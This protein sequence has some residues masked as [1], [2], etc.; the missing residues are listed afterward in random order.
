M[1]MSKYVLGIDNGGTVIKA[2]LY[3]LSG[4]EVAVASSKAEMSIPKP[5]HTERDANE[6]WEANVQAIASVI[7][8]SGIDAG[9]IVGVSTTGHGNGLYLVDES[10]F[11]VYPGIYSTDARGQGYVDEWYE[12]GTFDRVLPKTMQS[13]WSG[14]P[15]ALLA[16]LRDNSP[17]I[18]EKARWIL[19][20]KDYI[21]Y[22]LTGE[23]Y[24][25]IT[26]MSGSSL[27]N[28]RDVSYDRELLG[29]FGLEA[30]F[31]MLPPLKYS[32]EVCGY[33]SKGA[34]EKTGLRE[35]TPV[36]GGLFD[37][38]ACAI[39]T[40]I[41]DEKKLCIIAGTWSI[42]EYISKQPVVSKSLF[43]TTL[44][45]IP[46]YWLT[47]EASATSA[48]NLE[49]FVT[50]F[51]GDDHLQDPETGK[52][53]YD[54]CNEWVESVAPEETQIM[55]LPFLYGSNVEADAKACFLGLK[56]W[57]HK[58]HILRAL[59]EGVV[60]SHK[61]HIEKLLAF[62]EMPKVARITG[63]A[64]RSDV[65]CQIFADVLQIPIEITSGTEL[66]TL[67]AAM[68]AGVATGHFPS[69]E[70]ASDSMVQ[71]VRTILPNPENKAVYEEKYANYKTTLETLSSLWKHI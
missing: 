54:L 67:G 61:M 36:A 19:M 47:T 41:T 48:S 26:D 37:I 20:C 29:E 38:D 63:G 27:M 10:G 44:Y 12:D 16:W 34:A 39:A 66:G 68:C 70:N 42:N 35:G 57:H 22:R 13:I 65:W 56:G 25:E 30:C 64:A 14:Q 33:V 15:V 50:E 21:R 51:L 59:Y 28:V 43:M 45:C 8:Q 3:D 7:R 31:D 71:V 32:A 9:D 55:F 69:L 23:A 46:G 4:Q 60:F 58:A 1:A 52:S 62:R 6:L 11:P 17:E 49:W 2:V 53:V 18:L 5:G 40:G 24:A